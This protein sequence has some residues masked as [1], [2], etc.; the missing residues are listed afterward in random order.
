MAFVF[1][2]SSCIWKKLFLLGK[3]K[4]ESIH[5]HA[6]RML[7]QLGDTPRTITGGRVAPLIS[8]SI[9]HQDYSILSKGKEKKN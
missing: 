7:Q 5:D 4:K 1:Q 8:S 6:P 3:C 2:N 9:L